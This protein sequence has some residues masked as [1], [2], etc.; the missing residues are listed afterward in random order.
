MSFSV[1]MQSPEVRELV[2]E[3]MLERTLKD[4]LIEDTTFRMAADPVLFGGEVGDDKLYSRPG[5]MEPSQTPIV[6]GEDASVGRTTHEQWLVQPRQYGKSLDIHA[7]TSA[8]R[9][10]SELID[11]TERLGTHAARSLSRLSRTE[12]YRAALS[13]R[14][15]NTAAVAASVTVPVQSLNGF[16]T[17]RAT[18]G[19]AVR[20]TTVSASNPLD[21]W[22]YDTGSAAFVERQVVGFAYDDSSDPWRDVK[23][24]TLTLNSAVT[25]SAANYE[26]V[27][28]DAQHV[29][30]PGIGSGLYFGADPRGVESLSSTDTFDASS[31]RS[32][33]ARLRSLKVR[34][35]PGVGA[36]LG[37]LDSVSEAQL[38]GDEE[39]KALKREVPG[40]FEYKDLAI[41]MFQGIIW[42]PAEEAMN[43]LSYGSNE[44][45][46]LTVQGS[47]NGLDI[48]RPMVCG[49]GA[50]E[51]H[52]VDMSEMITDIGILGEARRFN[53]SQD[54]IMLNT[55]RIQLVTRPPMDRLQQSPAIT[56]AA[57]LAMVCGS[58]GSTYDGGGARARY[59]RMIV[60]EH[61]G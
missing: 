9:F 60:C 35:Y 48:H 41:G 39:V 31:V 50:L 55:D 54:G 53:L 14:T 44:P 4:S 13:G 43:V 52:Y 20:Y 49:M 21:V 17:R 38:F 58:D 51:E 61:A 25:I 16:T 30:R 28:H 46:P 1:I 6:P 24:G 15:L 29:V 3:N 5:E 47:V 32:I 26:I 33:T 12:L 19:T 27:A 22:V 56:W 8:R 18:D 59:Q 23:G 40:H 10:V 11:N 37:F 7:P 2:Q 36:Y 57:Q 42:M 34:K 45:L